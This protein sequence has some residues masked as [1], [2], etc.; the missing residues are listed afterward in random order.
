METMVYVA[1]GLLVSICTVAIGLFFYAVDHEV[2]KDYSQLD[3]FGR[4]PSTDKD[5]SED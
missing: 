1:I 4:K 5:D 2:K 3:M